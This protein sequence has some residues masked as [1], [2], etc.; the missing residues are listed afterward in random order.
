MSEEIQIVVCPYCGNQTRI[1]WVHGHGQCEFCHTNI[2]ECCRGVSS[3]EIDSEE[4]DE[5]TE[6]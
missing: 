3:D 4:D 6:E 2:D 1:V 5:N